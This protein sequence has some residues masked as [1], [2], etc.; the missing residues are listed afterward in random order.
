[1]ATIKESKANILSLLSFYWVQYIL[2][3]NN[4]SVTN[5]DDLNDECKSK[6]LLNKFNEYWN[7]YKDNPSLFQMYKYI[8]GKRNI[9]LAFIMHGLDQILAV[10]IYIVLFRIFQILF[11]E[12]T[13]INS[14][15]N[16][17]VGVLLGLI[18]VNRIIHAY[19]DYLVAQQ[20]FQVKHLFMV[21]IFNKCLYINA[22]NMEAGQVL[23]MLHKDL[24]SISEFT[25]FQYYILPSL[26]S[27][28]LF[29]TIL[30][31][32]TRNYFILI[33]FL[34]LFII[35]CVTVMEAV[36]FG[37]YRK[38]TLVYSDKRLKVIKECIYGWITTK[39]NSWELFALK[40]VNKY[41]DLEMKYQ[42]KVNYIKAFLTTTVYSSKNIIMLAVFL[43]F[44]HVNGYVSSSQIIT[45]IAFTQAGAAATIFV[46]L[47]WSGNY[48]QYKV[49]RIRVIS[50]LKS[51]N[52]D[53]L[54][55][56]KIDDISGIEIKMDDCNFSLNKSDEECI[57]NNMNLHFKGNKLVI[58]TGKIGSGKT[59]LLK[60]ILN[61]LYLKRG[62]KNIVGNISYSPQKSVILSTSFR[63][64]I[65]F[66]SEY[67]KDWYDQVIKCCGLANDIKGLANKDDT[68]IGDKG[69]NLSGGQKVRLNLARCV[70]KK[71]NIVLLD[72]P[73]SAV[74]TNVSNYIFDR[75]LNKNDG[76]LKDCLTI[77]VT[78]QV[79][80]L[81]YADTVVVMDGLKLQYIGGY[82]DMHH[83]NTNEVMNY[84]DY[85]ELY[86]NHKQAIID[87]YNIKDRP[88]SSR[89]GSRNKGYEQIISSENSASG[90]DTSII[91]DESDETLCML[92]YFSIFILIFLY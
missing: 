12:N 54:T 39:M 34:T 18:L 44:Y 24:E 62:T 49:S 55:N 23:N 82:N 47:F 52:V 69:V 10:P 60:S 84:V 32:L 43:S 64:N 76:I 13:G 51:T 92:V 87:D 65:L 35:F 83:F 50:F 90:V 25:K 79:Q 68:I 36:I 75:L 74:D 78:H 6:A 8:T 66:G 38:Q 16:G 3:P 73:L 59:L 17:Y 26:C 2:R 58:I 67:D 41:R 5:V 42:R 81:P 40:L 9:M 30:T 53:K 20:A 91:Q 15:V 27:S 33:T 85:N 86:G 4:I 63:N 21:I 72:D 48:N 71:C 29:L 14:Q 28:I 37:K 61:E 7:A 46:L 45:M 77:L 57:L 89:N 88:R 1:M 56:Q 11:A 31:I 70:Y 19:A 80:Y 22:N